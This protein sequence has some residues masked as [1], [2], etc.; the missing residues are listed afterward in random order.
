MQLLQK[1]D[2]LVSVHPSH[3]E[4]IALGAYVTFPPASPEGAIWWRRIPVSDLPN[5]QITAH[6]LVRL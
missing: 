6:D 1:H 3:P 5:D 4:R 2:W